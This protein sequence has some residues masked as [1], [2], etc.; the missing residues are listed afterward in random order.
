VAALFSEDAIY[1]YGPFQ[2]PSVGRREIVT[3][4]TSD[5]EQQTEV[6]YACV[7]LAIQDNLGVAHWHV[8]YRS[9]NDQSAAIEMDGVLVVKFDDQLR[10]TEHREWYSRREV[11]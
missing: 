10:C 2:T 6:Q 9:R 8:A 7:P 11:S 1:Y 4:W 3:S 5:P